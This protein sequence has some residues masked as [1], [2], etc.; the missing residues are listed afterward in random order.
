VRSR[1]LGGAIPV[2]VHTGL[3]QTAYDLLRIGA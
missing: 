2:R 1:F 3:S